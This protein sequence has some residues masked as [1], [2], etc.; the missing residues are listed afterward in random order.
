MDKVLGI[1][2]LLATILMGLIQ[3]G[4]IALDKTWIIVVMVAQIA[5]WLGYIN[6]SDTEKRYKIG[7]TVLSLCVFCIIGFFYVVKMKN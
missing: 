1:I 4:K 3:N 7:L 6:L 5:S 2:F